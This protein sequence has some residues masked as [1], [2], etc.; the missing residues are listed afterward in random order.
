[1]EEIKKEI[2]KLKGLFLLS[3]KGKILILGGVSSKVIVT[4]ERSFF[5]RKTVRTETLSVVING[6]IIPSNSIEGAI[7]ML[8]YLN[9]SRRRYLSLLV[10]L[11]KHGC[12]IK[13]K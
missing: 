8:K 4:E 1:M 11:Q 2:S 12:V 3:D 7:A 5:K 10:D 6:Q 9:A 13:T